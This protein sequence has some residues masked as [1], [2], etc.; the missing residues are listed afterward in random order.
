[1][2][3]HG[4]I[5]VRLISLDRPPDAVAVECEGGVLNQDRSGGVDA[6]IAERAGQGYRGAACLL[7]G[8]CQTACCRYDVVI[9]VGRR[10]ER[11]GLH[12]PGVDHR[13]LGGILD[14]VYAGRRRNADAGLLFLLLGV[15]ARGRAVPVAGGK[16]LV[17]E[18]SR[19][20]FPVQGIGV[21]TPVSAGTRRAARRIICRFVLLCADYRPGHREA[22]QVAANDGPGRDVLGDV[23]PRDNID[24]VRG[25]VRLVA[26]QR[27]RLPVEVIHR[28][29]DAGADGFALG[30]TAG[31]HDVGAQ[32]GPIDIHVAPG[33]DGARP[34]L[35]DRVGDLLGVHDRA[36]HGDGFGAGAGLA[37]TDIEED[38]IRLDV[39]AAVHPAVDLGSVFDDRVGGVID[40]HDEQRAADAALAATG[41]RGIDLDGVLLLQQVLGSDLEAEVPGHV[42]QL[43]VIGGHN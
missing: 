37:E 22:V 10:E 25:L 36:A 29:R 12:L 14:H 27:E 16:R 13:G 1:M 19:Q 7:L 15:V 30:Y 24:A 32:I 33:D 35:S 28:D 40:Q 23:D 5:R 3:V 18:K 34:K 26:D 9:V 4:R 38:L 2:N 17:A 41:G 20:G 31:P 8:E 39:E 11:S 6:V 42:D 21:I 43:H